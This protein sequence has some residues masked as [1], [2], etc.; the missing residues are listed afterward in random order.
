MKRVKIL[1]IP[2]FD[3]GLVVYVYRRDFIV[4]AESPETWYQLGVKSYKSHV[5]PCKTLPLSLIN[6]IRYALNNGDDLTQL[7]LIIGDYLAGWY[8]AQRETE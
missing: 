1:G 3:E 2:F 8:S 4:S 7:L 5:N 6:L